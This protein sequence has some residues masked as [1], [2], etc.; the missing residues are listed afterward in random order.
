MRVSHESENRLVVIIT[1]HGSR[2]V[3]SLGDF[4]DKAPLVWLLIVQTRLVKE[5]IAVLEA[6]DKDELVLVVAADLHNGGAHA[7]FGHL[8]D[9]D[10]LF[11]GHVL[12]E[13]KLTTLIDKGFVSQLEG[14]VVP[15]C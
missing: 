8:G 9:L 3:V 2:D 12:V 15:F 4:S 14:E 11:E 6:T 1:T 5:T 13:D 10:R 7:P